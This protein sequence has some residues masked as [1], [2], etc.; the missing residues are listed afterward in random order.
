MM[1]LEVPRTGFKRPPHYTI[2]KKNGASTSKFGIPRAWEAAAFQARYGPAPGP[3][4]WP[5][6]LPASSDI[7]LHL[8]SL[9]RRSSYII[10]ELSLS[11]VF[12]RT[13]ITIYHTTCI[14][15]LSSAYLYSIIHVPGTVL[16]V[17]QVL[18]YVIITQS[19]R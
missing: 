10:W 17:F 18:A 2:L 4:H 9:L 15:H 12:S 6:L 13:L 8:L 1:S 14:S 16:R 19:R 3:L 11:L 7:A 5:V